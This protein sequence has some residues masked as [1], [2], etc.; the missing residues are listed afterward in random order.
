LGGWRDEHKKLSHKW[1]KRR[2]AW[3]EEFQK[4]L[5]G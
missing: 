4:S 1:A 3:T 5:R 2:N